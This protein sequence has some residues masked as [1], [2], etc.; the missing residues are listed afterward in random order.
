MVPPGQNTKRQGKYKSDKA[1]INR[2][3]SMCAKLILRGWGWT[4][5][6]KYCKDKWQI[7]SSETVAKY[8]N[9]ALKVIQEIVLPEIKN[10]LR[11]ANHQYD[12]V[13]RQSWREGK[14][15]TFLA[16]R[17]DKNKVNGLIVDN[18]NLGGSIKI[19]NAGE[20]LVEFLKQIG[21][22]AKKP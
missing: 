3:V 11:I 7:T 10:E 15:M 19:E 4:E 17:R 12:M 1:E 2:R 16:A 14:M 9:A 8:Y 6:T 21:E 22:R 20:V 13:L 5:L 18:L